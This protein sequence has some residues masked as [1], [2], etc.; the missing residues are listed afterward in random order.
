MPTDKKKKG[1]LETFADAAESVDPTGL[2]KSLRGKK[3]EESVIEEDYGVPQ[4]D[5]ITN[6]A[7]KRQ[8]KI[9]KTLAKIPGK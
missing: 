9:K 1:L 8:E 2:V 5:D 4:L 3:K 7:M 6:K